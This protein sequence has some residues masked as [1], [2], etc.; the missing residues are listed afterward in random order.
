MAASILV[1]EREGKKHGGP[2]VGAKG[3]TCPL[4]EN[5]LEKNNKT[6]EETKEKLA[7]TK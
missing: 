1:C 5:K 4:L 6:K 3:G 7:S 2:Q